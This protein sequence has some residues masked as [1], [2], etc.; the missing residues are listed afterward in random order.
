MIKE[1]KYKEAIQIIMKDMPLPGVLGR[2][3]VRFCEEVCRRKEVDE[4]LSIKEMKRFAADQVD[5]SSLPFPEIT[6]REEKVAIVGSGPSGLS[7]AYFL[8]LKGFKPTVFESQPVLGGLL[9]L[10]IP[11]YRLPRDVL[12]R[13]I[14]N[15]KRLGV[16]MITGMTVG[17]DKTIPQ[18][19]EEGFKAVYLATG[20]HAG[21]K[22]GIPGEDN[23]GQFQQAIPWFHQVN[24]GKVNSSSGKVLIV[25]GGNA[26]IDAARMSLRL[27]AG[28]VHIVYRRTRAEMP[29]DPLEIE[30]ALHEGIHLHTLITPIRVIGL[31]GRL[32]GLECL[33]NTL[34]EPDSS[35]RRRPVP[36]E[37]SE[38]IIPADSVIAAIGQNVDRSFAAGLGALDFTKQGN[39]KANADT[40]ETSVKGV[41][42]GGDVV[43][44][45]ST[46]IEAIAQGK[47]AAAAVAAFLNGEA[48]APPI[49][50]GKEEKDH[51][52]IA[53]DEPR[54]PRAVIPQIP[55]EQRV[56]GFTEV[57]RAV[58]E[59]V[60]K[61]ESSRCLDCGLCCEC[62]QCV[63]A[64]KALAVNHTLTDRTFDVNVGSVILAPGFGPYD[65]AL[66]DTYHYGRHPNVMTSL[67]FERVLSASGPYG[68]HVV[69]PSDHKEPQKIAW[70]QCV[71]SRD[72]HDGASPYCSA[73]CCM[74]AIKEALVAKDHQK[75]LDTA[76]FYID[77]RTTGKDFERYFNRAKDER[78]VRFIKSKITN[79]VENRE[80]GN[81]VV[82]Y[83]DEAG[84]RCEEEFDIVVL[85][86]G[87]CQSRES[88]ELARKLG[89]DLDAQSFPVTSSFSPLQTSK[90]GVFI[91]GC[92]HSPK[93]IPSSVTDAS[94]AAANAGAL[95]SDARFSLTKEKIL[96]P[97]LDVLGDRPRVGVFICRCGINIAG[98]VDVT[99]VVEYAK[100]LPYVE[101][102]AENLFSCS[103]DTQENIS[104]A[105]KE[106]NLNRVV[107]ASCSPQTHEGLF[108]ETVRSAGVN[109]YLF[110]MANIRNQ[111]SWV[112]SETPGDATEKAKDLV[113]MATEKS[114]RLEPLTEAKLDVKQA[115][116]VIGGGLSG[117]TAALNLAQQGYPT[118]LVEKTDRLGGNALK[119]Y[120]TWKG[121][122]IGEHTSALIQA[123]EKNE[124]VTP[125]LN[126]EIKKVEGFVGN[127]TT[128]V[129]VNGTEQKVEHGVTII[130]TG[131]TELKPTQ[132]G[133]GE[134]PRVMTSLE[135]DQCFKENDGRLTSA[136]NAL[137]IQCV[138][139]RIPERPY[140]SRVC[141]T[142]S[143]KS[144]LLLKERNP[145]MNVFVLHRDMRTYGLRENLYR[146]A[147]EKG[148]RF[149]RY[150]N[151][152]ELAVVKNN[153]H[154]S[155]AFTD[156]TL[157]RKAEIRPDLL[158]LASAIV[159]TNGDPLAQQ[160]KIP[161]NQDGFF[162]EAHVKLR[163]VDFATDGV[164]LCGL[165][166]DPKSIDESVAQAQAAAAR[167]VSLLAQKTLYSS[168]IVASVNPA[169][170]SA[171]GVCVSICPYKAPGFSP[172]TGLAEV[173][174]VLCKG[175]GLCVASCRSGALHLNG[176]DEGQIMAM[177][178]DLRD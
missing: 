38:F 93:D 102:V 121:E 64:C 177:L 111:C 55:V 78:G 13:E 91:S 119:L 162:V 150:D 41:F 170:C 125:I 165:A 94:G 14:D 46:V 44:G 135:L 115:A 138:G 72:V 178:S 63:E 77:V 136:Q 110:E 128:T 25:G 86:I 43:T 176:F 68:G 109:K 83:T 95:L 114:T 88:I 50:K 85:S 80:T 127:F 123:I 126:A 113:K 142:H 146:E 153:G 166:H 60:A 133:Y 15:I 29:A 84:K 51:K 21:M 106:H 141:C 76:I 92:F 158:V 74:Y 149:L 69:R 75:G 36:I 104:K 154:L 97:E 132:Y 6:P 120:H 148:V 131:A 48:Y 173:N 108:Q 32:T 96:P 53:P 30:D 100:T 35:G 42:A 139:S 160:F 147:R 82:R 27:G 99:A 107:V 18:L 172:K 155:V 39:V 70:I 7:A 130:A 164:F 45:P 34:G 1:G 24:L 152:K 117:M 112:H 98:V 65:P 79:V 31:N 71:G 40:L 134:D 140:C 16:E 3:C 2:V 54:I 37:G 19:F 168:G 57:N 62:F 89:L 23:Y 143:V 151:E 90:L 145:A 124:R 101:H 118:Y 116:M 81:P 159:R 20:A 137:F 8:A 9:A 47:K 5:L 66:H 11:A 28:E 4:P 12:N 122:D 175:C 52:P 10:G 58:D 167:A 73:V 105:I 17:K 129:A 26:A 33:K 157:S 169:F 59:D 67:E 163:P 171:C 56:A 103:Q 144:A 49:T 156:S 87:L 61:K 161:L 174:P 22:L